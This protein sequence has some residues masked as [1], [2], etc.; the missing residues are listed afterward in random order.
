M[1]KTRFSP[2]D[3][4]NS[5]EAATLTALEKLVLCYLNWRQGLN[6][7]AW[8]SLKTIGEDLHIDSRTCVRVLTRL[9]DSGCIEKEPGGGRGRSNRYRVL[10]RET[11]AG[12]PCLITEKQGDFVRANRGIFDDKQ[13]R[14]TPRIKE[15]TNGTPSSSADEGDEELFGLVW[16]AYPKREFRAEAMAAWRQLNPSPELAERILVSVQEHTESVRWSRSLAE[17]GGRFVPTLGTFLAKRRWEDSP[18]A[19]PEP[20]RGDPGWLP[21]DAELDRIFA[22]LSLSKEADE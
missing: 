10:S 21:S 22:N 18:P 7:V 1:S 5:P 2:F 16:A 19:K 12:H 17:D 11:G 14:T 13:G 9:R 3:A 20:K 8:P 15:N 6:G 4:L